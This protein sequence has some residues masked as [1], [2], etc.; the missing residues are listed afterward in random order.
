MSVCVG[1]GDGW[2]HEKVGMTAWKERDDAL[3]AVACFVVALVFFLSRYMRI[4]E[5]W[6]G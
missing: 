5:S 4:L 6:V 2:F 1:V 3:V